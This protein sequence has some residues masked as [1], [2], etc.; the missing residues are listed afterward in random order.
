M[1][2][3]GSDTIGAITNRSVCFF[4]KKKG[5]E[6]PFYSLVP[7]V[8]IKRQCCL[9]LPVKSVANR[10]CFDGHALATRCNIEFKSQKLIAAGFIG[11]GTDVFHAAL[12]AT[13]Y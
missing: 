3:P 1:N 4:P 13:M 12:E 5:A 7:K 10:R 6:R 9:T 2:P 11:F 8:L